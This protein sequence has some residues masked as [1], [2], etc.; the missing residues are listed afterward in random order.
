M[1]TLQWKGIDP[2]F[3][4]YM[5]GF[6]IMFIDAEDK[7]S[8]VDQIDRHYNAYW[9]TIKNHTR[10]GDD[11]TMYYPDD[12]PQKPLASAQHFDETLYFYPSAWVVVVKP[13][14]SF[15]IARID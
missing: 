11:G 8:A 9:N 13:D 7:T 4:H 3:E 10:I 14:K 5:L 6:L 2:R 12:P 1:V 15:D